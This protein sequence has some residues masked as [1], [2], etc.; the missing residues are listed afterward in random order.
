[1]PV[2]MSELNYPKVI[3]KVIYMLKKRGQI[4][5][6]EDVLKLTFP[7][8]A[9]NFVE[10]SGRRVVCGILLSRAKYIILKDYGVYTITIS[11]DGKRGCKILETPEEFDMKIGKHKM[12]YVRH[13]E[14]S[15][16][17]LRLKSDSTYNK[18]VDKFYASRSKEMHI[19][20][21]D[22]RTKR[23]TSKGSLQRLHEVKQR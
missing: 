6:L 10:A 3:D 5:T 19:V 17:F 4:V 9:E 16:Y 22:I 12:L 11:R 13:L 8:P 15:D 1:M 23:R 14:L 20:Q 18:R 7:D 2:A 21:R